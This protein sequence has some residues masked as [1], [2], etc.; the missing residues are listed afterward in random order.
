MAYYN[1]YIPPAPAP[2]VYD[3][4]GNPQ[5]RLMQMQQQIYPQYL[6]QPMQPVQTGTAPQIQQPSNSIQWVQGKEGAKSYQ[7]QP[8][9]SVI[10]MDS[11]RQM[12]YIKSANGAGMP[13]LHSYAF[14]EIHEGEAQVIAPTPTADYVP[15]SDFEQLKGQFDELQK[16][17]QFLL[18]DKPQSKKSS[19]ILKGDA[20]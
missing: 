14:Q 3:P 6:Q 1:P 13:E 5:Q 4:T 15:K 2:S 20:E 10:L 16:Q 19:L 18:K 12:F 17:F 9:T 8:G 11:E 7:V